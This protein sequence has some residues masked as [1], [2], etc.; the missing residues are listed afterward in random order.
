MIKCLIILSMADELEKELAAALQQIMN[1]YDIKLEEEIIKKGEG[2]RPVVDYSE[3]ISKTQQKI[4]ELT[5]KAEEIYQRT[6]M[7]REELLD[8]AS[9]PHNFTKEQWES[10]QNVRNSCESLKQQTSQLL[11][12]PQ[13]EMQRQKIKKGDKQ[14]KRFA[15]KKHWISM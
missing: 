6:G 1:M 12:K 3:V 4:D 8:Y 5:Q 2:D 7:T 9:N 14:T 10:I 11:E 13:K 15:K